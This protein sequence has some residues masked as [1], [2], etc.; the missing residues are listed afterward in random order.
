MAKI[1]LTYFKFTKQY[2]FW[3]LTEEKNVKVSV[4]GMLKHM[5]LQVE[6]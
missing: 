5:Y 4:I 6:F 3:Y 1:P 2:Y